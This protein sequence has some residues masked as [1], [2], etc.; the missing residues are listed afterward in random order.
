M[1]KILIIII[2][3]ILAPFVSARAFSLSPLRYVF[4]VEPGQVLE[5]A[6]ALNNYESEAVILEPAIVG[7]KAD[8]NSRPVFDDT[9]PA[10]DWVKPDWNFVDLKEGDGK[11]VK[12]IIAVPVG[13][14]PGDYYLGVGARVAADSQAAVNIGQQLLTV[15]NLKVAG[16]VREDL[17]VKKFVSAA[18]FYDKNKKFNL[19]I[20]N[21]GNVEVP[22]SAIL[23]INDWRGRLVAEKE[24][25]IGNKILPAAIRIAEFQF[26]AKESSF[27]PSRYRAN[28][29]INYGLT[30]QKITAVENFWYVP[31]WIIG[32]LAGV[33]IM[34]GLAVVWRKN[35]DI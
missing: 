35:K 9:A 29:V 19:E 21:I 12:F 1:K 8:T 30:K 11:K 34:V 2:L 33:I 3:G 22:L 14:Y 16:E 6:V 17:V 31:V 15:V 18:P 27:W 32:V 13:V 23:V 5:M 24:V 7:I 10:V 4:A 25:N 26:A 28:L 20:D